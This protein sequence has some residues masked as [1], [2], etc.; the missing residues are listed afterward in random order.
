MSFTSAVPPAVRWSSIAR[1]RWPVVGREIQQ[2]VEF[3]EASREE[4]APGFVLMSFTCTVSV[5]SVFHSSR[6]LTPSSAEKYKALLNTVKPLR[7]GA[8]R[9]HD[10][11]MEPTP[12]AMSF[13]LHRVR[14]VCLPQLAAAD[15]VVGREIQRVI[16]Y[17][18]SLGEEPRPVRVD[19]LHLHRAA[20]RAV[21]LPQLAAADAVVGGE[22]QAPLKNTNS[23]ERESR[24]AGKELAPGSR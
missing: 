15:A 24:L 16:E 11:P 18:Q 13:N 8:Q 22:K 7:R 12:G 21:A 1:T 10:P 6:P 14:A 9:R 4:L 19:V 20:R 5:P 23:E 17:R 3:G 2:A